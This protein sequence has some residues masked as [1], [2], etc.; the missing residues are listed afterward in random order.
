MKEMKQSTL[1]GFVPVNIS[2]IPNN[3]MVENPKNAHE[4]FMNFYCKMTLVVE[5]VESRETLQKRANALWN[6]MKAF[7]KEKSF[8]FRSYVDTFMKVEHSILKTYIRL[9]E[10]L[11]EQVANSYRQQFQQGPSSCSVIQQNEPSHPRHV[12]QAVQLQLHD[13]DHYKQVIEYSFRAQKQKR[14]SQECYVISINIE[15]SEKELSF[16]RDP[17]IPVEDINIV[18]ITRLSKEV[19]DLKAELHKKLSALVS[20]RKDAQRQ[21]VHWRARKN[22]KLTRRR[23]RGRRKPT[24]DPA[25][26]LAQL[27][28]RTESVAAD[29]RRRTFVIRTGYSVPKLRN[30]YNES[31]PKQKLSCSGIR[32]YLKPKKKTSRIARTHHAEKTIVKLAK[33]CNT[34]HNES[35]DSHYV[36]A[37]MRMVKELIISLRDKIV[38]FTMDKKAQVPLRG[39]AV[40]K[41]TKIAQSEEVKFQTPDHDFVIKKGN[42][43]EPNVIAELLFEDDLSW[44]FK[45]AFIMNRSTV[46]SH[47]TDDYFLDVIDFFKL[48]KRTSA[49]TIT[50]HLKQTNGIAPLYRRSIHKGAMRGLRGPL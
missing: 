38:V 34:L 31:Y 2:K 39:S 28:K 29:S 41:S 25:N 35:I 26:I 10:Q 4:H 15:A 9:N 6:Q 33:V 48:E 20:L 3:Y 40:S 19:I 8:D 36:S 42:T 22:L 11:L 47:S 50:V 5:A 44:K 17:S 49:T 7:C 37:T 1:F 30:V 18:D 16:L 46:I 43:V 23:V 21:R 32:R 12:P 14:I 27:I 24:E 45:N 13:N